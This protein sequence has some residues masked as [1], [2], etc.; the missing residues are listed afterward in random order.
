M[1][2]TDLNLNKANSIFKKLHFC[3]SSSYFSLFMCVISNNFCFCG[4][5]KKNSSSKHLFKKSDR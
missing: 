5:G 1:Q 4:M 2:R 3:Y